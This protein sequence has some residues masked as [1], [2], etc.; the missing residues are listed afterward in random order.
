[1]F[2]VNKMKQ[3]ALVALVCITVG[4]ACDSPSEVTGGPTAPPSTGDAEGVA[5]AF[6]DGWIKSDYASMYA[7]LSP[8]SLIISREAF[9]ETYKQV[10]EILRTGADGKNY[11]LLS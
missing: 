8:K 3:I 1:M 11:E 9:T 5:R 6:L 4:A 7:L 10:D 2:Q